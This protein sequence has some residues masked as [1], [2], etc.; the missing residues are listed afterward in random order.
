MDLVLQPPYMV[1]NWSVLVL[2]ALQVVEHLQNLVPLHEEQLVQV[3]YLVR[4]LVVL[5]N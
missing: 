5:T 2:V 4:D 1:Q 3:Q